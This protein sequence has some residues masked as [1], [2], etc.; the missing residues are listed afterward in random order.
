MAEK[1]SP[2]L[3]GCGISCGAL[4]IL[5]IVVTAG[6]FTF[7]RNTFSGFEEAVQVK[8]ELEERFGRVQDYTPA[9]GG[10]ITA[11][12]I[13]AFLEVRKQSMEKRQAVAD[14]FV[15]IPDQQRAEQLENASFW[16][17]MTFGLSMAR[18]GLGL[19]ADIGHFFEQRNRALLS[20]EMGIG[21]YVYIYTTAYYGWLGKSPDDGPGSANADI[22]VGGFTFAKIR[23]NWL[24]A[25]ERAAERAEGS[26]EIIEALHT[27][28][29]LLEEDRRRIP[30]QD[31][32]PAE[33]TE[34][35][36]PFRADL[37]NSYVA[38]TNPFELVV[39][40]R[41]GRFGYTSE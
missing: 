39:T 33:V 22:D 10:R 35:L 11:G 13:Q 15:K 36:E 21:E 16:E 8:E 26:P 4:I 9:A 24:G 3:W 25:L 5:A 32:L 20:Q 37:D 7:F 34:V 23:R 14:F 17:K 38:V 29:A 30:W 28:L 1:R 19:G 12:R 6:G 2:W 27:E 41:E 18:G 40:A 31:G